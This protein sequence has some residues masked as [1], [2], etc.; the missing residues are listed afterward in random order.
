[1]KEQK[2]KKGLYHAQVLVTAFGFLLALTTF[3][4]TSTAQSTHRHLPTK[5]GKVLDAAENTA[6]DYL[7]PGRRLKL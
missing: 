4:S 5:Y 3:I 2:I 1:M 6:K 7:Y